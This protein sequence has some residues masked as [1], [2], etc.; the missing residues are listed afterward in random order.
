ME[1]LWDFK[2]NFVLGQL[3]QHDDDDDDDDDDHLP[4]RQSIV[5]PTANHPDGT[6]VHSPQQ[7]SSEIRQI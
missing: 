4:E 7:N 2:I 6:D 5:D 3:E 1:A